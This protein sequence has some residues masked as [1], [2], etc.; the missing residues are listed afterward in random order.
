MPKAKID[1][2]GQHFGELEVIE[3]D[4]DRSKQAHRSYWKCQCS[5]GKIKS[6]RA[7][8]IVNAKSCGCLKR[9]N[10]QGK[11]IWFIN[12]IRTSRKY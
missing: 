6:I 9:L 12:S 7:S 10:L 8:D 2:L 3:Y 4:Q 5:C 11:K 1:L